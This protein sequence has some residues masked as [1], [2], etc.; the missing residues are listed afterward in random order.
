MKISQA[1][2]GKHLHEAAID[3]LAATLRD[4]GYDVQCDAPI[5]SRDR[6]LRADLLARRGDELVVYEVKVL[7]E[8]SPHGT[9]QA[10]HY[11]RKLGARFHMVLVNPQR[12]VGIELEGVADL[13]LR[14]FQQA[15]PKPLAVAVERLGGEWQPVRVTDA[16][17]DDIAVRDGGTDVSGSAVVT[18]ERSGA[19]ASNEDTWQD[20]GVHLPVRFTLWLDR[21]RR[22]AKPPRLDVD[23][24]ELDA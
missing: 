5:A 18:L 8:R 13:L 24:S 6:V 10:E 9:V 11:A 1:I 20:R 17:L 19:D 21:D 4:E 2:L 7:G 12:R 3:Q 14:A 16:E 23:I 22:F 15:G